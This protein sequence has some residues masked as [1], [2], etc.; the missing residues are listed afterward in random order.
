MIALQLT[1]KSGSYDITQLV[2]NVTWSGNYRQCARNLSFELLSTYKD[3]SIPVVPCELGNAVQLSVDGQETFL[4]YVFG[5][6]KSLDSST[7]TVDC[8][9]RGIYLKRNQGV[10]QFKE[11]TPESIA[12]RVCGDFGIPTGNLAATGV[13]VTRNFIGVDL[14]QIIMTA[15]TLAAEQ[16]GKSYLPVFRGQTLDVIE[17]S[18]SVSLVIEGKVNLIN[19]ACSESVEKMVNQVAIY[20]KNNSL[21]KTVGNQ[22]Y[23]DLYGLMQ[24]Y[25]K[26]GDEEE[27]TASKAQKLL[28]DNGYS[29]KMTV[30][31]LGDLNCITGHSVVVKEPF[32]GIDGLFYIDEDTHTWKNGLYLNKLVLN[33]KNI[34]DEQNA[35]SEA[36]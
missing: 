20:D 32:T 34:M 1:G 12:A 4:G 21:L 19:A 18:A 14:Y 23:I 2:Q 5:R 11:Q 24:Q 3:D 31:N 6:S 9:D 25:L 29:Q 10:Y 22:E 35:G 36:N 16:T 17:K 30:E 15:Y 27:D 33:F 26:Q 13:P 8:F 28:D 7:I